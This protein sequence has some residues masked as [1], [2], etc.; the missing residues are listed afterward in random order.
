LKGKATGSFEPLTCAKETDIPALGMLN[1][2]AELTQEYSHCHCLA[3]DGRPP[4]ARWRQ[5]S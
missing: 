4:A 2:M 3:Q 1:A 5:E